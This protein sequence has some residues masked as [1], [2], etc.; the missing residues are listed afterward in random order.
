MSIYDHPD[1]AAL[2]AVALDED[3]RRAGDLTCACLVP[4]GAMLDC[5][6]RAKSPGVVCGLPIFSRVFARVGGG[7]TIDRC[8]DDGTVVAAGD[9]V[10]HAVGNARTVLIA[11]RTGL[12]ICQR[13]SGTA[14]MARAY[15]D[16]VR[17]T[18]ACI[19]DTRKTTPGLRTLEKHAVVAGGAH[20]HRIGLYDQVLIKE[21]HIALMPTDGSGLASRPAEAVRRCRAQL[22]PQM[23]VQVEV[24]HLADLTPCIQAGAD[25][26]LLDNMTPAQTREAVAI[27]DA[28][29][30]PDGRRVALESSGGI[31]LAT[32]RAYAEAGVD[33]I[34][35]GAL[36]HSVQ[37]LDLS[38]RCEPVQG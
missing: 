6:I 3:L 34:S 2:I 12:N 36:T 1:V 25:I 13:L 20:N 29:P 9:V 19:L 30:S 11:E 4:D 23:I 31:T 18:S 14:T 27:R 16:A 33:R 37:A 35:V 17:G 38:M 5:T 8:A 10:F 24:E 22:G 26:V 32:V 21:N 15:A 7:V 28:T